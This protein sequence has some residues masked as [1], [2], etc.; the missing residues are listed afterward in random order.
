[1]IVW[2]ST[3]SQERLITTNLSG[4]DMMELRNCLITTVKFNIVMMTVLLLIMILQGGTG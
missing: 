1:M 4:P 2:E 3:V